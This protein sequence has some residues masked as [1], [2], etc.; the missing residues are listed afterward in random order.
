MKTEVIRRG[1][2]YVFETPKGMDLVGV[3]IIRGGKNHLSIIGIDG[4][5]RRD[6]EIVLD[7]DVKI[8]FHYYSLPEAADLIKEFSSF[9]GMKFIEV[10][11]ED[12][13]LYQTVE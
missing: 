8:I 13:I 11:A 3:T 12:F 7:D 5:D 2:H 10:E 6:E 9:R 4:L 1:S